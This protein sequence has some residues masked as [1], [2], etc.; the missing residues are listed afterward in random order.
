M[1]IK[2]KITIVIVLYNSSDLI[3]S[4]LKSLS[5]FKIIIVDN[6]KNFHYINELRKIKNI[7]IISKNKNLGYGSGINFAFKYIKTPFFLVLNPDIEIN[8]ESIFKL[9]NT[10]IE[11]ENCAI[12]APLNVPD[13]DSFG[14]FPEKRNLY[15]K[16]R[17]NYL[18]KKNNEKDNLEGN[19][20]VDV[21]KGC[22]LLLNSKHFKEVNLFSEKYFLF[23]E[24]ID[25]CRKFFKK[26]L[27]VIVNPLSIAHHK[28]GGSSKFN[29]RVFFIRTYHNELSPLLYFNVKKNSP[30]IYKNI[31]KYLF[32]TISYIFIL[33]FKDSI[34]NLSKLSANIR[35]I[36]K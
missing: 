15:E 18:S 32:R 10:A 13:K 9:Y 29:Y 14:V 17:I 26:K 20:C 5:G 35:F 30:H 22:A 24:E 19:T 6:G 2:N 21:T 12:A 4:C 1:D 25:L 8:Q 11:N 7:S 33:N 23:W 31:F 36:F 3:F 34:K 27:S 28:Q 16:N